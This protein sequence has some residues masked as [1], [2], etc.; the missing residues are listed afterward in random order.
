MRAKIENVLKSSLPSPVVKNILDSYFDLKSN[1]YLN[2]HRSAQLEG[3]RFVESVVRALEHLAK[4]T[5][6]PFSKS[7]DRFDKIINEFQ[8]LP[9]TVNDSIRLHIPRA[10]WVIYNFR[11]K[12]NVGH[13]TDQI[14]TNLCDATLVTSICDWVLAELIRLN[15]NCSPAEAQ[16]IVNDLVKRK[17]PLIEDF[18]DFPKILNPKLSVPKKILVILYEKGGG[19]ATKENLNTWIKT[20]KNNLNVALNDLENNRALIHKD[21]ASYLITKRG[22]QFVEKEISFVIN[23]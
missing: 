14:D 9:T 20:S 8:S 1:F 19:G 16:N 23:E 2:N 7:L 4:G 17:V 13:I 6:T 12:R 3:G 11:N 10:L 15:Y 5:H 18:D 21:G 22:I